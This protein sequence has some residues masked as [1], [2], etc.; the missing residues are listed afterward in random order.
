M[1]IISSSVNS[2]CSSE[3]ENGQ[4]LRNHSQEPGEGLRIVVIG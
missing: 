3:L 2:N 4:I 1:I